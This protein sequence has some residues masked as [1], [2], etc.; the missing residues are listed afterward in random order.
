MFQPVAG[1][2]QVGHQE[3]VV[4][5]Q[6]VGVGVCDA[7]VVRVLDVEVI[8]GGLDLL[9]RNL[10]GLLGLLPLLPPLLFEVELFD[11]DGLR[12]VVGL[13][14]R[15]IGVLVEP[16]LFGWLTLG[17]EQQ[18]RLDARVRTEDAVRQRVASVYN[19]SV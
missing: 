14:S 8:A 17:E 19:P 18:V 5:E 11:A 7:G 16:N 10:P 2:L 15:W 6:L 12:L 9:D 13:G 4:G 1:L 3:L